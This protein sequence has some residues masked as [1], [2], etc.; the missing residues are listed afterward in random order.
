ME[1][2]TIMTIQGHFWVENAD[3]EV[4]FDP[5]FAYYDEIIRVNKC[6][7]SK[8]RY[9]KASKDKNKKK[10]SQSRNKDISQLKTMAT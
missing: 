2:A 3:G 1:H 8:P 5:Y 6:D 9:R 7:K 10:K 4:I